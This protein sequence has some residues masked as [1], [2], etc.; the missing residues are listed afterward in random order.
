LSLIKTSP[1]TGE[2]FGANYYQVRLS[3]SG[4]NAVTMGNSY[5]GSKTAIALKNK[6]TQLQDIWIQNA[7]K[8]TKFAVAVQEFGNK[9]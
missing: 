3:Q 2:V 4:K 6:V 7:L 8:S 5:I 1:L 9:I